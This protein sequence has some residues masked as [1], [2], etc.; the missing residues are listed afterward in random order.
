MVSALMLALVLACAPE[1]TTPVSSEPAPEQAVVLGW[2]ERFE[3]VRGD[4]TQL[5]AAHQAKDKDAAIASW[6]QAYLQRF[7]PL[8]EQP[9]GARVDGRVVVAVE[10]AFGRLRESIES[11]RTAPVQAALEQLREG[12]DTLESLV[13]ALPAPVE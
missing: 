12:L 8:I 10:Y 11:P 7:E 1:A 4:L 13:V 2:A 6:Q 3:A 9:A 5:E